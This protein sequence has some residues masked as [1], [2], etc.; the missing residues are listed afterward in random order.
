[1]MPDSPVGAGNERGECPLV[2]IGVPVRNGAASLARALDDLLAQDY[3]CLEIVISENASTDSTREICEAYAARDSRIRLLLSD[4]VLGIVAN[5]QR[6]LESAEGEYFMWAAA[7]DAWESSFVSSLV[8]E[9]QQHPEAGVA[10]CAVKRRYQEDG[11]SDVV[12]FRGADDVNRLSYWGTA[13]RLTTPVKLV[14]FIY[15]VFRTEVLRSAVRVWPSV[16]GED[17]ILLLNL[18]LATRFRYVD[19]P[20]HT[21]TLYRQAYEER[22]PEDARSRQLKQANVETRM[23]AALIKVLTR[24]AV[25][26]RRRLVYLPA[27]IVRYAR[28]VYTN[29]VWQEL[30]RPGR[31]PRPVRDRL[32][33]LFC[34]VFW[35]R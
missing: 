3:P 17:R 16:P 32:D 31:E 1:M 4:E 11:E 19:E 18:A 10:M 8:S 25:I 26:P 20:L 27:V 7:D 9:L 23:V 33:R 14:Y 5:F 12:Y 21:Q 22:R 28:L 35:P 13:R 2:S 34:R 24:S 15:G 30:H 29:G 6:V